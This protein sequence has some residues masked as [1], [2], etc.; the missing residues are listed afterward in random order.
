M[1]IAI[2]E[3]I[4]DPLCSVVLEAERDERDVMTRPPRDP[5]SA[6]LS[7]PLLVTAFLQGA[8]AVLAVCG[9]FLY[10]TLHGLRPRRCARWDSS[11]SSAPTTP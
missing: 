6:L 2:L 9:V 7:R 3:L 1:L 10:A 5:D 4:I 11:P 8:L